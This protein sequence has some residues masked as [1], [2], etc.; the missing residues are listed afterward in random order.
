MINAIT[1][2]PKGGH[3]V[4]YSLDSLKKIIEEEKPSKVIVITYEQRN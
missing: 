1:K 3:N 2:T 4:R